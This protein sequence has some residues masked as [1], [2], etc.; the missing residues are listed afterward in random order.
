MK[1]WQ[2][3]RLLEEKELEGEIFHMETLPGASYSFI[4]SN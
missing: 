3:D 1:V 2:S 4:V